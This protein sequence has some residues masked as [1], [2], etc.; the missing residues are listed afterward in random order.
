[1]ETPE[2]RPRPPLYLFLICLLGVFGMI[3]VCLGLFTNLHPLLKPAGWGGFL[4][5][6]FL[7]ISNAVFRKKNSDLAG[8]FHAINMISWMV[9]AMMSIGIILLFGLF[10]IVRA[11]YS[12]T[13]ANVEK[14]LFWAQ[15]P[16]L[17][18]AIVIVY[19]WLRWFAKKR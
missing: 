9:T 17:V 5:A 11:K 15:Y 19:G 13:E 4:V 2:K 12:G 7:L 16:A 10:L 3:A 14:F 6:N 8:E 18:F 1:M